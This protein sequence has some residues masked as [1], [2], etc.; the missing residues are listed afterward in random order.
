MK[1]IIILA[2][3]LLLIPGSI[4][5]ASEDKTLLSITNLPIA[6][7]W[8]VEEHLQRFSPIRLL[9]DSR[10]YFVITWKENI[11]HFL[12][13]GASQKAHFDTILVGKRI[14]EA[15]LL[16]KKGNLKASLKTIKRYEQRMEILEKEL[17]NAQKQGA[18]VMKTFDLL[19][20]NLF[21]HQ[22]LLAQ[23]AVDV[24]TQ[25]KGEFLKQLNLANEKLIATAKLLKK[26]RPDQTQILLSRYKEAKELSR[27]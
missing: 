23:I 9:P 21:R 3:S 15:Y 19:A 13:A 11:E 12:K 5:N 8:K 2:I 16:E 10:F 25:Q 17:T 18:D 27:P 7:T 26:T 22:D 24:P 6:Q 1:K 20:D 14:K 4:V